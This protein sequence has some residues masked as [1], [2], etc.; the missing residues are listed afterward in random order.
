[1]SPRGT[2]LT[3]PT[4]PVHSA[5]DGIAPRPRPT[6]TPPI[7][8]IRFRPSL[9]HNSGDTHNAIQRRAQRDAH[10]RIHTGLTRRRSRQRAQRPANGRPERRRG[11]ASRY[12]RA[13][14]RARS[15]L[16]TPAPTLS[17][18]GDLRP[19]CP[20]P[21][22]N[23]LSIVGYLGRGETQSAA[24]MPTAIRYSVQAVGQGANWLSTGARVKIGW[25]NE[26]A[27]TPS[28]PKRRSSHTSAPAIFDSTCEQ[29]LPCCRC[30]LSAHHI[31]WM[32][33]E[34]RGRQR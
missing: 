12:T 8:P 2:A 10:D 32:V 31:Q 24:P 20:P 25:Q 3:S 29:L 15:S 33:D 11:L 17:T 21:W 28:Q 16:S 27:H 23:S 6:A 19:T 34:R 4:G 1:M 7:R 26:M 14:E 5:S 9:A 18:L 22:L 30:R 13:R